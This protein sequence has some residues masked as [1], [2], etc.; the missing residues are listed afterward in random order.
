MPITLITG[1]ANAGKAGVVMDALTAHRARGVRPLL[2]VPTHA[3]VE[4]YRLELGEHELSTKGP[5][6]RVVRFQGLLAE[7][8]SRA[9][10]TAR[11]LGGLT[12]ERA[13]A[14]VLRTGEAERA[15]SRGRSGVGGR[16]G[17][18]KRTAPQAPP[19]TAGV[20]RALT[21]LVG[22]L[23]VE[24]VT[25]A[26][27][28]GALGAWAAADPGHAPHARQLGELSERYRRGL[29]RLRPD[30]VSPERQAAQALDT[31][32]RTPALW[33]STPLLLYG[34]DDFTPLQLDT[35]ETLGAVVGAPVTVALTYEPGRA[36]FAS[37]GD[38]FQRLLPLATEHLPLPP[39]AEHYAPDAAAALNHLERHLFEPEVPTPVPAE[40][41]LRLLEGGG[42]RAELE[43]VAEEIRGLLKRGVPPGEIAV[44]HRSP[45]TIAELL[46]EI[47]GAHGIPFALRRRLAFGRTAT[48]RALLGLL[49]ATFPD[50]TDDGGGLGDLLAW[51]RAPG[52]LRGPE[53]VDELE[54]RARRAGVTNATRARALWE[55]EHGPLETLE[56]LRA[57]AGRGPGALVERA[58]A[59][60][61]GL[62]FVPQAPI[63]ARALAVGQ[64]ALEELRD[65]AG[66]AHHLA[67]DPH[68]LI[69]LLRG[70]ELVVVEDPREAAGEGLGT[71][72]AVAVLDPLALRARR[73]RALFLC[74]LQEGVF[75]A[76]ARAEP[77]LSEEERRGLAEASGLRLGRPADALGGALPAVRGDLAP[78]RVAGAELAY[79]RRRW[80]AGR[81][82]A[83]RGRHLRPVHGRSSREAC[84]TGTW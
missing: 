77:Y 68:E 17:A 2:V 71:L 46:G 69:A 56:E 83:V 66:S 32:R 39:R 75:P 48:G 63:E 78:A 80:P 55:A 74:G 19:P 34:F 41:A 79:G 35:I 42:E 16:P 58:V 45:E 10:S 51:L 67:P 9:G 1:P 8:L 53:L 59:E 47:F 62:G 25:P 54:W 44:A 28:H 82:L 81:P 5:R 43:L 23:E 13:L 37:R 4:R 49:K 61:G 20:V 65:L 60:L 76:P 14:A 57:A 18:G 40:A 73:V 21:A 64:E 24:R 7:V 72:E 31:L 22:E 50:P 3:D 6:A 33:G 52:T 12:R 84:P 70:L 26:R 27:L 29:E 15:G 38:T 30:G 11:P 36:A